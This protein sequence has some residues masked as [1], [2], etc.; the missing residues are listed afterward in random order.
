MESFNVLESFGFTKG[1]F[2]E[3]SEL[4][5]TDVIGGTCGGMGGGSCYGIPDCNAGWC[6][7]KF[8]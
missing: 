8:F 6:G 2:Q 7:W 3:V 5:I 1:L 4:E